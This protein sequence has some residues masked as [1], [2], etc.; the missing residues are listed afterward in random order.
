[1][2]QTISILNKEP[3]LTLVG[4]GPGDPELITL[5]AVRMLREADVIL[6]DALVSRE[7][8]QMVPAETPAFSVGKRA[9]E[10]SYKQHEINELIVELAFT[11]GHVVRLKGGDPFVFGRGSEEL[12]FAARH[13]IKTQIVPGV[14][15]AISVPASVNIPVTARGIS[16]SFWVV[17]GTTQAGA[18]SGDVALAAQSTATIVILMGLTK[19]GEIVSLFEQAGKGSTPVAIIQNGTLPTQKSVVGTISTIEGFAAME[20]ISS[21]AVIVVGEV[22][23]MAQGV[24]QVLRNLTQEEIKAAI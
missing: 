24:E 6:Y 5:K 12:E 3:R 9:G 13:G 4:A 23:R 17:T 7:I 20:K 11:H 21:P 18:I 1:M 8:L 16:E 2:I 19:L 22:V 15:S 14:S 10:H